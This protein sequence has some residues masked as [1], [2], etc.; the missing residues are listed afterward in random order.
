VAE[1][2]EGVVGEGVEGVLV[3]TSDPFIARSVF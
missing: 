3:F 2:A 1:A